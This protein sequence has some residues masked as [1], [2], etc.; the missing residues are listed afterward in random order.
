MTRPRPRIGTELLLICLI[1]GCLVGTWFLI[2][3]MHRRAERHRKS[4]AKPAAVA[5]RAAASAPKPA[6]PPPPPPPTEPDPPPAPPVEDP[7][8]RVL[9]RLGAEEAEQLLEAQAS[10][11]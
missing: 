9:A 7:T 3:S 8:P 10:D 1:L 4:V 2:V 6:A 5:A 11:R